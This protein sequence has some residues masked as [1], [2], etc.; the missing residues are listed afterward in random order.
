MSNEIC[1]RFSYYGLR[2]ILVLYLNNFLNFS[3]N[4]STAI[5]HGFTMAAYATCVLGGYVSDAWLGKYRT[6]FYVSFVS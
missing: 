4:S 5:L 6:I 3:E 2:A 1:E